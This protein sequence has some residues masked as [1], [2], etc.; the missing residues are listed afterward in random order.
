M[1]LDFKPATTKKM[2]FRL[3]FEMKWKK[4][5]S[6]ILTRFFSFSLLLESNY[7]FFCF[8]LFCWD[9]YRMDEQFG[10]FVFLL[11]FILI[12]KWENFFSSFDFKLHFY[13]CLCDDDDDDGDANWIFNVHVFTVCA[14]NLAFYPGI[15]DLITN[16]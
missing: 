2:F 10:I 4:I 5:L 11:L 8:V 1:D 13:H 6:M 7:R 12:L 16:D 15:N 3:L 14:S 9:D